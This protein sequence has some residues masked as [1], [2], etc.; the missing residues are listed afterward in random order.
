MSDLIDKL[1]SDQY[2]E[3]STEA[4]KREYQRGYQREYQRGYRLRM[5]QAQRQGYNQKKIAQ[6]KS[7]TLRQI[8]ENYEKKRKYE[9]F[10]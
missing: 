7:L 2:R 1:L 6:K 10:K 9:N 8:E 4:T 3:L 5:P